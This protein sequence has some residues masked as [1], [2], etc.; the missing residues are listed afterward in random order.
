MVLDFESETEPSPEI[1]LDTETEASGEDPLSSESESESEEPLIS[2]P[3][4]MMLVVQDQEPLN[5]EEILAQV[6]ELSAEG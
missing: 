5:A 6:V 1:L 3:A 2:E 4:L